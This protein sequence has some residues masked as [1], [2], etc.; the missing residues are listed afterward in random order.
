MPTALTP[1][2]DE[3]SNERPLG[4]ARVLELVEQHVVVAPLESVPAP[5]ELVHLREQRQR[6]GE[7]LRKIEDAVRI[8]RLPVFSQ[9]DLVDALH[10]PRQHRVQVAPECLQHV[11]YFAA[12]AKHIVPVNLPVIRGSAVLSG[13]P[14][15]PLP[16]L[17]SLY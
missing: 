6:L 10:G 4:A 8:E 13:I 12:D 5:R 9:R 11:R 14:V 15:E 1:G 17:L 7:R 3:Q 2:S 16:R